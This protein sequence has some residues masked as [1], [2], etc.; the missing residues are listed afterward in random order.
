MFFALMGLA[1]W[2]IDMGLRGLPNGRCNPPRIP[3]RW[4]GCALA[5]PLRVGFARPRRAGQPVR[6]RPVHRFSRPQRRHR[7]IRRRA[8]GELQRRQRPRRLAAA[9]NMSP[10]S[11]PVYQPTD[12]GRHAGAGTQSFQRDRRRH[13]G[14]NLQFRPAQRRGRRLS[15]GRFHAVA[16][17]CIRRA[18]RF[19]SACG[20]PIISTGWT[21]SRA[22]APAGPTLPV[23]FGR[24]SMMARSGSGSQLSVASGITVRATAIAGP[25][26]AKTVGPA[27]QHQSAAV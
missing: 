15:Q 27:L 3:R 12:V 10:G 9:Q 6:R 17:R 21:R 18:P 16:F 14:G 11:P 25:Q 5:G 2:L 23:L 8:G 7:P 1:A 26:P 19:W 22:S 20:G 13:G 4:K 24:G